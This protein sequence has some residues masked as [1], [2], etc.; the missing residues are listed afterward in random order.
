M[1]RW[2]KYIVFGMGV[3]LV[4]AGG[5]VWYS[6][7]VPVELEQPAIVPAKKAEA[8]TGDKDEYDYKKN[9]D[10]SLSADQ[11]DRID[12]VR[13][14]F[15]LDS[16]LKSFIDSE[17]NN[18]V[19]ED[20]SEGES[21]ESGESKDSD[22]DSKDISDK[23]DVEVDTDRVVDGN[24]DTSSEKVTGKVTKEQVDVVLDSLEGRYTFDRELVH[25]LISKVSGYDKDK[26]VDGVSGTE[27][28]G[29]M[30]INEK[31]AE[32]VSNSLGF[33]YKDG[34]EFVYDR[35][36]LM[37]VYYLNYLRNINKDNH[38]I[39]TAYVLGPS[40]ADAW[41]EKSGSYES[42]FSREVLGKLK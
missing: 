11:I 1:N 25:A 31:T 35:N 37:G 10:V 30:V 32:S 15:E 23:G 9:L 24:A 28:R 2:S 39:L 22:V 18:R 20:D 3:V 12:E 26:V 13:D 36:I 17:I 16:Y 4:L 5:Y 41:K 42:S 38:Y 14:P 21:K 6:K 29:I 19:V 40:G 34:D 7:S 8:G 27:S 33:D